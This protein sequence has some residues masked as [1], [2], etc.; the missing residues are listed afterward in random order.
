MEDQAPLVLP[1]TRPPTLW[2]EVGLSLA[3]VA[4]GV[5]LIRTGDAGGW[6][7]LGFFGLCAVLALLVPLA[8]RN[9]L[10]LDPDGFTVATPVLT[11]SYRWAEVDRFFAVGAG[12]SGSVGFDLAA[13]SP[14]RRGGSQ[15]LTRRLFGYDDALPQTYGMPPERLAALLNRWKARA[16]GGAMAPDPDR[17]VVDQVGVRRWLPDGRQEAVRWDDLVE[18]AIRTTPE[19]PWQEDV[20][21][22]L[23]G[24]GGGGVAVP[25]GEAVERDLLGW[26]Q[27]LPGFDNE[28]VVEAMTW[29]EDAMFVCWRRPDPTSGQASGPER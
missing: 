19:G 23:T 20:F 11:R 7:V 29:A 9:H 14:R 15:R 28:R 4:G 25:H 13:A 24:R 2:R 1:G 18:V 3:F 5:W 26:L 6:L 10:R 16:T 17:V 8:T 21:F 22:L 12:G 27:A